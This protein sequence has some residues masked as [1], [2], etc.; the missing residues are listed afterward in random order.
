MG[1]RVE[2][3]L[4]LCLSGKEKVV[5]PRSTPARRWRAKLAYLSDGA[6]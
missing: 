6:A 5:W 4:Y 1:T 3:R 2:R